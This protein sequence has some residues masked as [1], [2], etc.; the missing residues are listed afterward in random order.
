MAFSLSLVAIFYDKKDDLT[1]NVTFSILRSRTLKGCVLTMRL[2]PP[3]LRPDSRDFAYA[4]QQ[5]EIG[6]CLWF[7]LH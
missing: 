2:H 4:Q 7:L 3:A 6:Q 5:G 1:K